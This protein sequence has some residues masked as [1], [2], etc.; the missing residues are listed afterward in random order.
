MKI[1]QKLLAKAG[2]TFLCCISSC[3][4]ANYITHV[5]INSQEQG[6]ALSD[7]W[8]FV[9]YVLQIASAV[10][11]VFYG[12]ILL[13]RGRLFKEWHSTSEP[14]D[15]ICAVDRP[16]VIFVTID[17]CLFNGIYNAEDEKYHGYDG[18]DFP[19]SEIMAWTNR[20]I[21]FHNRLKE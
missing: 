21:F 8:F 7:L 20:K 10:A 2:F 16:E 13:E 19:A 3:A 5:I 4:F 17:G 18:L 11:A 12:D 14:P 9:L 6:G 1:K 15:V